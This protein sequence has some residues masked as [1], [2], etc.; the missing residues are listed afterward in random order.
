MCPYYLDSRGLSQSRGNQ[1][2]AIIA[3]LIRAYLMLRYLS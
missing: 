1:F 3:I 2:I